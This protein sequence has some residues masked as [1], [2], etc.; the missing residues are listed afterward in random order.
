L[1]PVF[2]V[3]DTVLAFV[4]DNTVDIGT[5]SANRPKNLYLSG[6]VTSTGASVVGAN[7]ETAGFAYATTTLT[8]AGNPGDA[9]KT[10][11]ALNPI[12]SQLQAI[13]TRVLVAGTN[14]TS[15]SIGDGVDPD[16]WGST[17]ALTAGTTT[18]NANATANWSNPQLA[19]G[20]VV[21]TANGGNCF[22]L[23]VRVVASYIAVTA[24]TN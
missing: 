14:C 7:G 12:G 13:V 2:D 22:D 6:T 1:T 4:T 10:A 21:L 5:A 15:F 16:L 20:N 8:F 11:I 3:H 23:S 24:P 17:I 19:A 18:T 9:S